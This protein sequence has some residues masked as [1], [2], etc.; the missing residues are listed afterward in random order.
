M[1]EGR[2][3]GLM[4]GWQTRV[5]AATAVVYRR[6]DSG[7]PLGT[8]VL[9]DRDWL[10]T[11]RHV[12]TI[13]GTPNGELLAQVWVTLPGREPLVAV[14]PDDGLANP[15]ASDAVD[16]VM[17]R[18]A[19]SEDATE[20]SPEVPQP[21]PVPVPLSGSARQPR[22]VELIGYPT[23]DRTQEG[24]WRRFTVR[25][26]TASGLVQV[27]WQDSVGSWR[28]HS[29]G[30]VVDL[31]TGRLV[32]LLQGG[33]VEGRF[34]RYIPL[35]LLLMHR[36]LHRLPWLMEGDDAAGHFA[37]RSSGQRAGATSTIDLFHGRQ[38]A[39]TKLREWLSA[40]ESPGQVMVVT[41]QPGAGKSAVISR[42]G[43]AVA[44]E[45]DGYPQWRG[46]M[47][48]ARNAR[49]HDFR[50]AVA[51][52]V[53]ADDDST[54]DTLLK[55]VDQLGESRHGHRWVVLIDGLDEA[56]SAQDR[57]LI[58]SLLA[59]LARRP[60]M[61]AAVGTRALSSAG[62][63]A[64]G[65]LLR[66]FE[67]YQ[68]D[69]DNLIDL[70]ADDY[71]N[72][73][74]LIA[75]V[76]DLL[77]QRGERY[78][79]P[80]SAAWKNYRPDG[81]LRSAVAEVIAGRA[82]RNYLVAVLTA[83]RL[84][85]D[86]AV[87]D[88]RVPGFDPA[89]LPTSVGG[90]LD[91]FL[92]AR[93]DGHQ[94]RGLLV[95]LAYAS[96]SGIDDSTWR[97]FAEVLGYPVTQAALD[98]LR[99]SAV[100]DYLLQTTTEQHG[101][102]CRL[103]HQALVDH[104][105][106][107]RD[108][109]RDQCAILATL[110]A[111]VPMMKDG[112]RNWTKAP[113]YVLHHLATHAA[114]AEEL[115]SLLD[116]AGYVL[117]A[118]PD[119]LQAAVQQV[120]NVRLQLAVSGMGRGDVTER[121]QNLQRAAR[122]HGVDDL[123]DDVDRVVPHRR[124][125]SPWIHMEGGSYDHES[126][127]F[128]EP[129]GC[130]TANVEAFAFLSWGGYPQVALSSLGGVDV[131]RLA[132]G[133]LTRRFGGFG[134]FNFMRFGS[135]REEPGDVP[136]GHLAWIWDDGQELTFPYGHNL[137]VLSVATGVING[138]PVIVSG[139][140]D[141]TVALWHFSEGPNCAV[142]AEQRQQMIRAWENRPD[143]QWAGRQWG[144]IR[145]VGLSSVEGRPVVLACELSG[146]IHVLDA[147]TG[148]EIGEPI[149]YGWY[150]WCAS[151]G[152]MDGVPVVVA[153]GS[154]NPRGREGTDGSLRAWNIETRQPI[155]PPMMHDETVRGIALTHYDDQPA[156]VSIDT[157]G[158]V[159]IWDLAKS[160]LLN[161][162]ATQYRTIKGPIAIADVDG[163]RVLLTAHD[164]ALIIAEFPSLERLE[165]I[166][167]GSDILSVGMSGHHIVVGCMRGVAGFTWSPMGD[168]ASGQETKTDKPPLP[169]R[170]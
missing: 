28:G 105:L 10:L 85:R 14:V 5:L 67:V 104:L 31:A 143:G 52:L 30:P 133:A 148:T 124:W 82:G 131:R 147:V 89:A 83:S 101:L 42:G 29:G 71:F 155:G 74:D 159:R 152:D 1:E 55:E 56:A 86:R 145:S 7:A 103:F 157:M 119:A 58:A 24:V 57:H 166:Y 41:G 18:R 123:A 44:R 91:R 73:E 162:T 126:V 60:W 122:I 11:C 121:A 19:V 69:A 125:F 51:D 106:A 98:E 40:G 47:F 144:W 151:T 140:D 68:P 70:D 78:P 43:L 17:L 65:S 37:R 164:W 12:V 25:G 48:H 93:A 120:R 102:V 64:A 137:S 135:P 90:A 32:G 79:A 22:D 169:R 167:V 33:S 132:D 100:A 63:F 154:P 53:G 161:E 49:A 34:D 128:I 110:L 6:P 20:S 13:D 16:A 9:V 77:C 38:T 39:V 81:E 142:E 23:A 160:R 35:M 146:E 4:S 130:R 117:S 15:S 156:A 94:L 112:H 114:A 54:N 136:E 84:A 150:L 113:A 59:D 134:S 96:G 72:A 165:T 45:R 80:P 8:A 115:E 139:G 50:S 66:A 46:L 95:A 149:H 75:L 99:D 62:P 129:H 138:Q 27:A 141:G 36:V 170:G 163:R 153:G 2:R 21:W 108:E 61:R 116:D 92:S 107:R 109:R 3:E 158:T 97:A 76:G 118:E 111:M 168:T 87:I 127:K 26:P 88:P